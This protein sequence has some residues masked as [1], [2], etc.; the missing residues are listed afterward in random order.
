[1]ITGDLNFGTDF[2]VIFYVQHRMKVTSVSTCTYNCN[3]FT[4]CFAKYFQGI[5]GRA[6]EMNTEM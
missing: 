3:S 5:M 6:W 1:V 4:V 2:W